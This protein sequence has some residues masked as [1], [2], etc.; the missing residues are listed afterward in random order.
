[1]PNR[2]LHGTAKLQWILNRVPVSYRGNGGSLVSSDDASTRTV[3]GTQSFEEIDLDGIFY[4]CS[5]VRFGDIPDGTSPI[6]S[7]SENQEPTPISARMD[8]EWI[9]GPS[10]VHKS[11]LVDA[12]VELVVTEFSEASGSFFPVPNA[13]VTRP[14]TNGYLMEV[15]FGSFHTGGTFMGMCMVRFALFRTVSKFKH[16]ALSGHEIEV[17]RSQPMNNRSSKPVGSLF[18]LFM[19]L[20]GCSSYSKP[21]YGSLKPGRSLGFGLA[22]W[23]PASER[24]DSIRNRIG[25]DLFRTESP[26]QLASID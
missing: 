17:R 18:V 23:N 21:D 20:Q 10:V 19:I 9:F 22:R 13:A 16:I 12:T 6:P 5:K 26:M 25:P 15:A 2:S 11:T 1:M 3:A 8:K 7:R 24:R 4:G 14:A